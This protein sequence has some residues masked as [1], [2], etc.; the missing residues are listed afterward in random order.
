MIIPRHV[1]TNPTIA[2]I[3]TYRSIFQ[4]YQPEILTRLAYFPRYRSLVE[5]LTFAF[6]FKKI[7]NDTGNGNNQLLSNTTLTTS[8]LDNTQTRSLERACTGQRPPPTS[9]GNRH[10]SWQPPRLLATAVSPSNRAS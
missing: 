8:E 5:G 6:K 7:L 2:F 4:E 1:Y 9:P 10:V 3:L